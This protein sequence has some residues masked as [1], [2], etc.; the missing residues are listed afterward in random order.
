MDRKRLIEKVLNNAV[1]AGYM[2]A[3]LGG[4]PHDPVDLEV[5]VEL[6][7]ALC[8]TPVAHEGATKRRGAA[9]RVRRV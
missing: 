4:M 7:L 3:K 5:D 1:N 6:L 8:A 9:S 2:N